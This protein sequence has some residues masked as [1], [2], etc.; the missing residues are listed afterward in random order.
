VLKWTVFYPIWNGLG[1]ECIFGVVGIPVIEIAEACTMEGITFIG[2]RNEQ[3]ASYAANAW[4]LL[5]FRI[6]LDMH[7]HER[8]RFLD[9]KTRC[10]FGRQWPWTGACSCGLIERSSE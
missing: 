2:M 1:V 6:D 4:G 7:R 8:N 10:L 9:R 3:S 5:R